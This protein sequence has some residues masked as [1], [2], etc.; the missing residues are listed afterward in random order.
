MGTVSAVSRP[1]QVTRPID[2]YLPSADQYEQLYAVF[3]AAANGCFARKGAKGTITVGE[4][5]RLRSSLRDEIANRVV[6][7][8]LWG[9]FDVRNALAYGYKGPPDVPGGMYFQPPEGGAPGT[10]ESCF[11]EGESALGGHFW[12]EFARN[13]LLPERGPKVPAQDSRYVAAVAAW[14]AC[15]KERGFTYD[16][17]RAAVGDPRWRGGGQSDSTEIATAVADVECKVSTNLVG[18]G[19]AVQDA[20]DREYIAKHRAALDA[21]AA[22]WDGYL[23]GAK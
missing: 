17:P 3:T 23:R 9:F 11:K 13:G 8:E 7:S 2:R 20:Y 22:D 15:I 18:I 14:R 1:E 19:A 21:F 5:E 4:P 16:D 12:G 10:G 6:R